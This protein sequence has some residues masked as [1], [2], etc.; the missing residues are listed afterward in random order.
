MPLVKVIRNGQITIPKKFRSVFDIEEGD[1]LEI[2][3]ANSGML[4][5]PKAVV[6]KAVSRRRL[7]RLVKEMQGKVKGVNRKKLDQA[8]KEAVQASK[9]YELKEISK[10]KPQ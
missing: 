2:E 4:I 7:G 10:S 9:K 5:K 3:I 8:I 1:F 6:D